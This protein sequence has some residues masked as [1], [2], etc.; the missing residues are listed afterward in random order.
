MV[1]WRST[2][3]GWG[4]T[5]NL[6]KARG[7]N[8]CRRTPSPKNKS[9]TSLPTDHGQAAPDQLAHLLP[10][11]PPGLLPAS[12][13]LHLRRRLPQR[14]ARHRQRLG[15]QGLLALRGC[16]GPGSAVQL[17]CMYCR[18]YRPR[19][20]RFSVESFHNPPRHHHLCRARLRAFGSQ[21]VVGVFDVAILSMAGCR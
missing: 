19:L 16:L 9:N 5:E 4:V 21:H 11:Q 1:D 12:R 13:A 10:G 2:L 3:V 8:R 17:A 20:P 6:G 15:L 18:L 7:R 14:R